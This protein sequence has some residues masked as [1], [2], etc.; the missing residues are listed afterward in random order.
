MPT[1]AV[2]RA[3]IDEQTKREA[4]AVLASMGLTVPEAIRILMARVAKDKAMPFEVE[5][6]HN[7]DAAQAGGRYSLEDVKEALRS[8]TFSH[9][10]EEEIRQ[11]TKER[12]RAKHTRKG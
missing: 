6:E 11:G 10:S 7:S 4:A 12:V 8:A 2:V 9:R 1:R 5:K 3:T